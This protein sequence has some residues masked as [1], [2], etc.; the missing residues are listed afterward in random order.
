[1]PRTKA[2][3]QISWREF[4]KRWKDGINKVTPMQQIEI[5]VKFTWLTVIGLI[6][7]LAVTIWKWQT[8]WWVAIILLAGL[9][10][11]AVTM[12]GMYQ[13]LW[14]FRMIEEQMK[15]GIEE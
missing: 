6:L 15:G 11:T 10:N 7:G 12:I 14:A 2:G 4:M 5:Q 3:E 13:K 9:G 8:F 1:M